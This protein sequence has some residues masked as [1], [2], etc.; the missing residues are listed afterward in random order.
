MIRGP[1]AILRDHWSLTKEPDTQ[2]QNL[3][4]AKYLDNLQEKLATALSMADDN[5]RN[6]QDRYVKH[7]NKTA[8]EKVFEVG[9]LVLVLLP[10]STNKLVSEWIGPA[11][12]VAK[13][14]AHSYRIALNTG[15]VRLL[16]ANKLRKFVT[17]V[18]VVGVVYD[19]DQD[20]GEI[21][22]CPSVN[23]SKDEQETIDAIKNV[24]L[25][26][27]NDVQAKL[28][29]ELLYKHRFVF[30]NR[31]GTCDVNPHEINLVEGFAPK[32]MKPYRIPEALKAEVDKQ[33]DQLLEDG[34]IKE[35]SSCFA[36]PIV[37]VAKPNGDVRMCTDL[38]YVNS[39]TIRDAY[40]MPLAED[41]LLK[42]CPATYISTLDCTSGYW[43]IPVRPCD[44]Y[45]TAFVT[46]RGLYE[47]LT[48]P[49]GAVTASQTFQR[50][51]DEALR[52]HSEYARAYI[53]DTACFSVGWDYHLHH[54]EQVFMAFED[55]GMSL[56]FSKC[57]FALPQVKFIGHIVGSGTRSPVEDKVLAIKALPEPHNKKML[58]SFLG[59]MNFYRN[60]V[61]QY[62]QLAL[63]LTELTKK[64]HPNKIVFNEQQRKAFLT[65]KDRLCKFTKLYAIDLTLCFHLFSDASDFAVGVALTQVKDD[66]GAHLPVGF[67]SSKLTST[68]VRWPMVE[69]EAYAILYGLKRFEHLIYGKKVLIHTDH[70]PL[71]YLTTSMA[72]SPK[73]IRWTIAL[74]KFDID[75][76]H[77]QGRDNVV[78]DYLSRATV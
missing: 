43:Q 53:D 42:I 8:K 10:T 30:S 78:A 18:N 22:C 36:H 59:A 12:V 33:V 51:M 11:T 66:D 65:L 28:L 46:H 19:E 77:I 63:P 32:A 17:R 2:P 74:S 9:D 52:S 31:P 75:I 27:L 72:Q 16:H 48:L 39:G 62:S 54:L 4:T 70:N 50:V 26:H 14:S 73:L 61:P 29:R 35:S 40:P 45:K 60:Y 25:S 23:V 68:Q 7:Y 58:R 49:F 20:F 76:V 34:K 13:V 21:E 55:I 15:A 38:R 57:K 71:A 5:C 6:A 41:M 44:T 64:D 24:D 1:L 37:C 69:K 3:N 67:A 56:K 47:W